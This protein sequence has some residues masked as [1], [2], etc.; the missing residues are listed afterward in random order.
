MPNIGP[1]ELII[2]LIIA[3][4]ILGPKRLPSAGRSLGQGLREFRDGIAGRSD[5]RAEIPTSH[6]RGAHA[7]PEPRSVAGPPPRRPRELRSAPTARLLGTASDDDAI[8]TA[9]TT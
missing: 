1:T 7:P 4:L 9:R 5:A 6:D 8:T 3:L 2:V